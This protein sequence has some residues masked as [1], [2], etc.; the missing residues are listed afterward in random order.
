MG[1]PMKWQRHVVLLSALG[2]MAACV[3]APKDPLVVM[4]EVDGASLDIVNELRAEGRLPNFERL[5]ANGTSGPL[6]SWP[7][8]RVMR[9]SDRR[10][11][12][13]P[14]LWTS[15]ATGKIPEK[16]GVR[17]FVLP[18]PGT[19]SVWVGSETGPASA[20]M[21]LPGF[22]G[23]PPYRLRV[24]LHAFAPEGEQPVD[25]LWNDEPMG[26]P[27]VPV[28]W[29][30]LTFRLS[31]RAV[32]P[33]QNR[34]GLVFDRQSRPSDHGD[35]S[36]QRRLAGEVAFVDIVDASGEALVTLDPAIDRERFVRGF[37]RPRGRLTEVQSLHWR[38][39][40]VWSLLGDAGTPV[41][42]IGHWGTWP[43]YPVNGF[44]VSSRMGIGDTRTG[45]DRLT[46]PEELA[47]EIE[48]LA[49]HV[50]DLRSTF[51]R[52]HVS[53]C[54]PPVIDRQSV[55]KKL[56][57]QDAYYVRLAKKLL[58]GKESG[59]FTVYLRAIDAAG[60]VAF[61]W[62]NGAPLP[63]GCPDTVREI[64]AETYVQIDAWLGAVVDVLPP[65]ARVVVVS[66]HGMQ[67]IQ[68][69]GG[70]APFG[71]VIVSGEHI[72]QG[73]TVAGAS[74]LDVAPTLLYLFGQPVPLDMD[75]H[76]LASVFESDWLERN[77]SRYADVD[78]S[79]SPEPGGMTEAS[80]DALEELRALGYIE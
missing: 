58:A 64:M 11:L 18:I 22:S 70:H 5:I 39:K 32:R 52:L 48:P 23:V 43:A 67:Q 29:T 15:I 80:E 71:L 61:P 59:L 14:I 30:E 9:D 38:A 54:E 46:W 56:L 74:I 10:F 35:S 45:S 75:G 42:I 24:K 65:H 77:P 1:V 73:H 12:A 40:P 19:A 3:E 62:R 47:E 79:W 20:E 4:I 66:D 41:G 17:D 36:D 8:H 13:S 68:K 55:L 44:L 7:S 6:Q 2:V 50:D 28:D 37:Y 76:V 49:P 57:I 60:H 78:T 27:T 69:V 34:L 53:E 16:H 33:G 25:V 63:E 51:D 31:P 26:S 21:L 72:Q